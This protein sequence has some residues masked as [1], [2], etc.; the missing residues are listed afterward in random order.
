MSRNDS[1]D[2]DVYTNEDTQCRGPRALACQVVRKLC[3]YTHQKDP[4]VFKSLLVDIFEVFSDAQLKLL[5][6]YAASHPL[7]LSSKN[8]TTEFLLEEYFTQHFIRCA[9]EIKGQRSSSAAAPK[10]I[11]EMLELWMREQWARNRVQQDLERQSD[12]FLRFCF[13]VLERGN[14]NSQIRLLHNQMATIQR[15]SRLRSQWEC[16]LH[17]YLQS[18]VIRY[19][20]ETLH[21]DTISGTPLEIDWT[22]YLQQE[23]Y[24]RLPIKTK[25]TPVWLSY[26]NNQLNNNNNL[27]FIETLCHRTTLNI[28]LIQQIHCT[29][30]TGTLQVTCTPPTE[31]P[32]CLYSWFYK[33]LFNTK[34]QRQREQTLD[35]FGESQFYDNLPE[36]L[37]CK[38]ESFI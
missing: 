10:S 8:P 11:G 16:T 33:P 22:Y 30:T 29:Y 14:L 15:R 19:N 13:R 24:A 17:D 2:E 12:S 4:I 6:D 38:I 20:Q 35:V 5:N 9:S 23:L 18:T 1:S 27:P 26:Y 28:Q 31:T 37:Q 7:M 25:W 32:N 34:Q 36:A 21:W 3:W